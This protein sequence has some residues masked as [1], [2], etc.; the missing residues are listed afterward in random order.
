LP[1]L[2]LAYI[3]EA[4]SDLRIYVAVTPLYPRDRGVTQRVEVDATPLPLV[5]SVSVRTSPD[6]TLGG[7]YIASFDAEQVENIDENIELF[8]AIGIKINP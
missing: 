8:A 4:I 2:I 6:V 5:D 1:V 3:R 7:D